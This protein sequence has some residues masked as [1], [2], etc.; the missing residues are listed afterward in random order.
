MSLAVKSPCLHILLA[1]VLLPVIVSPV[2]VSRYLLLTGHLRGVVLESD[3]VGWWTGCVLCN[4]CHHNHFLNLGRW[5]ELLLL[6]RGGGLNRLHSSL[7]SSTW[8]GVNRGIYCIFN[9][10]DFCQSIN[11]H[12]CMCPSPSS[13]PLLFLLSSPSSILGAIL[14]ALH[15][16][17]RSL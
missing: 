9:S 15:F 2:G 5:H 13:S 7:S 8:Q 3:D 4:L 17:I 10:V 6:G 12:L 1:G 14:K 16:L 11:I